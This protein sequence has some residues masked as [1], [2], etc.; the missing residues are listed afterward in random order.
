MQCILWIKGLCKNTG[1][2]TLDIQEEDRR[3]LACVIAALIL[4][5]SRWS[6]SVLLL[7]CQAAF[8]KIMAL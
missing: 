7:L 2:G 4:W 8:S 5:V 6:A 1:E 3:H